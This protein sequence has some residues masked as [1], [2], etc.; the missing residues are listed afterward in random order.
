MKSQLIA[1]QPPNL[2]FLRKQESR[3]LG[4]SGFLVKPGMTNNLRD[5]HLFKHLLETRTQEVTENM[6]ERQMHRRSRRRHKREKRQR[7]AK[8]A[9]TC[10]MAKQYKIAGTK[11]PLI[12]VYIK[13]K[14]SRFHN[15]VR[16]TGWLTPTARHLLETHK[17]FVKSI[18]KILPI[19]EVCVEYAEF[20]IHKL[21]K[22]EIKGKAY[23]NGRKKGYANT[24]QYV[25]CRDKHTCQLCEKGD[26]EL[27]AHHVIWRRNDGQDVPENMITLCSKC[28]DKV[29]KNP[30]VDKK[31]KD[32]FQGMKKRYV[33]PTILNSIMPSFYQWLESQ[34]T[35]I[36]KTYGYQ[37]KEKRR[38]LGCP[39][40][41]HIDAYLAT[42]DID[43]DNLKIDVDDILVYEFKQFRRHHRQITHAVR[44]R[45]YK[46]GKK[47]IAKNRRKRTGQLTDSL[48]ELL[49]SKDQ[50][51]LHSLRV[52]P[53]KKVTR[54]NFNEFSKG[55]VV[56]YKGKTYVVKGYGEMGRSLG[57][58]NEKKYVP[59]K[60]C[61]LVIQN[62]GI[63]CL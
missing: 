50:Q 12:C 54:S 14:L 11:E 4:T 22:P 45:N 32:L 6:T 13:P 28:H 10:F 42:L 47:I 51:Y 43:K 46:E 24:V 5:K 33:H 38:K 56:R 30:K 27:H 9:K 44:D 21:E 39:K 61:R 2:S 57:F 15:R 59:T 48:L 20:N 7:R 63:V 52:L 49:E 18:R 40:E 8:K 16:V 53:G 3:E 62:T 1:S 25:L 36:K 29:H 58:V 55:D 31:V 37:T 26:R 35:Q 34:F 60:D 17:N 19:A 41:H 23:Q